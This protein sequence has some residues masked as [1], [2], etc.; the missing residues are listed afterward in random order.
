MIAL[1]SLLFI[2]MILLIVKLQIP[3]YLLAYFLV[4][5][6][7]LVNSQGPLQKKEWPQILFPR[8]HTH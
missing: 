4:V 7:I 6:I 5:I 2:T 8:L 1:V 3:L